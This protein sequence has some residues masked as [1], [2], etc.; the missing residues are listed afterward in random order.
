MADVKGILLNGWMKF[1]NERYGEQEVA[2]TLA[3]LTPEDRQQ[4]PLTF[5]DASWY[6]Y[7]SLR[8]LGRLTRPLVMKS[9]SGIAGEIG[10][11]MA[12]HAFNGAYRS[13]LARDPIKQMEKFKSIGEFFFRGAYTLETEITG[14]SSGL[15]RY[16]YQAGA[17]PTRGICAS[18]VG[19]WSRSIELAGASHVLGTHPKCF[20][21]GADCCEFRL[22]WQPASPLP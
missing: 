20:A 9:E 22:E 1:L 10:R 21:A 14:P 5:L 3:G 15:A 11:F 2:S 12:Q 17:N 8:V 18:L 13:L 6:P 19:F 16:R 4:L 7:D